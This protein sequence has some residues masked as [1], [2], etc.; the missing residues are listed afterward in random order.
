MILSMMIFPLLST[1]EVSLATTTADINGSEEFSAAITDARNQFE[2]E[3]MTQGNLL[4]NEMGNAFNIESV[5]SPLNLAYQYAFTGNISEAKSELQIASSEL[6]ELIINL[7]RA[8]QQIAT[9]SENRS[10]IADN[11]TRQMMAALGDALTQLGV[12]ANELK[13][14]LP[15]D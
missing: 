14:N 1:F 15:T 3:L 13:Q 4:V 5:L 2:E 11:S 9:I 6:D 8:G 7:T 12:S 10:L